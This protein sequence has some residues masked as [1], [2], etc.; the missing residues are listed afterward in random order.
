MHILTTFNLNRKSYILY[1]CLILIGCLSLYLI[2]TAAKA[3]SK[4]P[5]PSSSD[6]LSFLDVDL[7][8]LNQNAKFAFEGKNF[9]EAKNIY[10]EI[11]HHKSNDVST[12]YN[13]A[14]CYAK[15]NRPE[16]AAKAINFALVAGLNDISGLL[17]DSAWIPIRDHASFKPILEQAEL[18]KKERGDSFYAECKILIR[19][20]VRQPDNYDS[21][22]SYPLLIVLH[23]N[24]ANAESIISIRDRMKATNFFVAA[25]Q[26]PYPRKIL[27]LNT[28]AFS[29]FLQTKNKKLWEKADPPVMEYILNIIDDIKSRFRISGVYILGHSQGGSLAYMTGVNNPVVINGIIC[30]GASNP[31]EFLSTSTINNAASKL[32]I[33]IGHGWSDPSVKFNEAQETKNMFIKHGFNVTFK[34]F[35]GGHWL[36]TNTLIEAKKWIEELEIKRANN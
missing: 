32:P 7:G 6:E 17:A 10:L 19:G 15:L 28:P 8:A 27:A 21:T 36:D 13:L 31:E 9:R 18:L 5:N 26:G 33:F 11:L 2:I 14:T 25:P 23:G 3:D 4:P 35:D 30:F 12:L 29:W 20:Q 24:G 16:L 22:K 34:P 1:P